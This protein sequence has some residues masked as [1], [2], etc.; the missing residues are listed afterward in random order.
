MGNPRSAAA[1]GKDFPYLA[2]TTCYIEVH[3]DGTVSQGAGAAAYQRAVAGTSRLFAVWPGQWSGD[4]FAID[5][6]DAYARA[7]G[8]AH[9]GERTGLAEHQHQV[10]WQPD[11][12]DGNPQGT[13]VSVD[14]F[15][16]CGCGI[17]DLKTFAVQMRTQRGWDVATSG[18]YSSG[19]DHH[20][21]RVRRRSLA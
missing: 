17:R 11:K 1:S 5:D 4:L 19:G 16:D 10:R 14:V 18:G 6:L 9:D 2:A 7:A 21:I 3:A 12:Y 13:Y 20:T 8:L 15:F